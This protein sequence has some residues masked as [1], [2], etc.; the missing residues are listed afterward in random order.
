MNPLMSQLE[1]NSVNT[2][3]GIKESIK[4]MMNMINTSQNPQAV[5]QKLANENPTIRQI[6]SL[7]NG[8]L[9]TTFYSMCKEKGVNPDDIL[10]QLR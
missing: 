6:M 8:D 9:K 5:I 10:N 7:N 1:N 4:R 2:S 3:N